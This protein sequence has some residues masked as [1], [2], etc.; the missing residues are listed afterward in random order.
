MDPEND[1]FGYQSWHQMFN[2]TNGIGIQIVGKWWEN[3]M[4]LW[5]D[6]KIKLIG[7]WKAYFGSNIPSSYRIV[8]KQSIFPLF[9]LAMRVCST[10]SVE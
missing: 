2:C 9:L 5:K 1:K 7:H 10:S 4:F 3:V 6:K 8:S